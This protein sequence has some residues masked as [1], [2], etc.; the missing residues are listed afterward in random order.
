MPDDFDLDAYFQR[1]GYG[2]PA[3]ADL[4]TLT[5]IHAR[6]VDAIPFENLDPFTGKVPDLDLGALQAKLVGKRR[7]GYCFELNSLLKGALDALGFR[8]TGLGA[9]VRWGAPPEA[10]LG[11]RSH[12]LLKVDLPEGP[13]LADVGFGGVLLDAPLRFERDVEQATPAGRFRLSQDAEGA[14][15]LAAA[16]PEGWRLAY[17]FGPE[18]QVH[19]DYVMSNWFTAT[20]PSTWFGSTLLMERLASDARFSLLNRK[21]TEAGRNGHLVERTIDTADAFAE[22]LDEVFDIEPPAP[23]AEIFAR[24]PGG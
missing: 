15:A 16:M 10:P 6:Q 3:S 21:L 23:A 13:F 12:M 19:A 22:V 24:L 18:R 5:A 11:P 17:I 2:G 8:I 7:G 20:S 4:E 1:I 14:W 9:R